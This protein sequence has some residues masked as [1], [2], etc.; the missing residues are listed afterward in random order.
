MDLEF[1]YPRDFKGIF[2]PK[3]IWLND[4]LSAIDKIIFAEIYSLDVEG[5]DGCYASNEYLS[6]FC[7]CSITKVS[8]SIS[9]LIKLGYVKV[10]KSDGRKRFLKASLSK[11][12]RQNYKKCKSD[13]Q[14]MKQSNIDNNISSD[15]DYKNSSYALSESKDSSRVI[16][17]FSQGKRKVDFETLK[18]ICVEFTNCKASD[19]RIKELKHIIDYFINQYNKNSN[20]RHID[21][22]EQGLIKIV[23]NYFEPV[24]NYMSENDVYSFDECYQELIDHYLRDNYK[25]DVKKSLQH[26][27]SGLIRENLAQKYLK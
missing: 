8:T 22:L 4:D 17:A 3:E 14:K 27:M 9:N 15:I 12:E 1:D 25:Q 23:I 21:I 24:G 19:W 16:Y 5:S 7:K 11:N 26:F 20:M 2:I 18:N 6:K 10:A 13:I